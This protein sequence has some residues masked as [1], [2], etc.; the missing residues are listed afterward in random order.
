M[1]K[2]LLLCSKIND[3]V[4]IT[5]QELL[6]LLMGVEKSTFVHLVTETKVRM[7][8]KN[9]PYFDTIIKRNSSNYLIGN[10]Y[11]TRVGG[12]EKKEGLEGDFVS[13]KN[14]QGEHVSKC[15]LYNEKL[16]TYYLQYEYFLESNP[17]V[18]YLHNGNS[19]DR[20]LFQS[21]EVK[22]SESSR[23]VQ[24]RKVLFQ[25]FKI[26]NIKEMTLNKVEYKV[27]D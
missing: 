25:S 8:K 5:R 22:K 2:P 26:D 12:N 7:N 10:E 18:D 4:N 15:V 27:I 20:Q 24:E 11:E 17:K 6:T 14:T 19:I 3:M 9:N 13:E 21:F 16:N 23:Q 1:N